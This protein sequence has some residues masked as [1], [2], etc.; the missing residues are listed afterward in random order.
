MLARAVPSPPRATFLFQTTKMRGERV[1]VRGHQTMTR[2]RT[3]ESTEYARELRATQTRAESLL[4][5]ALRSRRLSGLK[6]RRQFPIPPFIA[7]FACVEKRLVIELDGGYHDMVFDADQSRQ[8]KIED[9]GW[10]VIRFSNEDV[11]DNVDGVAIAV[12]RAAGVEPTFQ[13]RKP[14]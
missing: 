4:W 13:G 11:L 9:K 5:A 14:C 12:A 8:K 3:K 6:F 10:T 1:R 7:D 2:R